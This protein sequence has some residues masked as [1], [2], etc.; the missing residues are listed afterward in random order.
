MTLALTG[1]WQKSASPFYTAGDIVAEPALAGVWQEPKNDE[2]SGESDRPIWEF[3]P[4]G[5]NRFDVV[6]RTRDEHYEYDGD[7]FKLGDE[8]FLDLGGQS[9]SV[10]SI[11][12]HHLFKLVATGP[13]LKLAPLNTDWMQKW[14]RNNPRTLVHIS[15]VD[16]EHR[17]DRDRDERILTA[18]TAALQKFVREHKAD[19]DFFAGPIVLKRQSNA[20]LAGEKK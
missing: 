4:G 2:S 20:A 12:A 19:E 10:G 9:R 18:D 14:L 11:P 7:V 15:V 8:R 13:E 3:V 6:I 1:C 16:P 5:G 17:D